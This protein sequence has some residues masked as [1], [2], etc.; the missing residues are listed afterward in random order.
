M[1][2]CYLHITACMGITRG[3][4]YYVY[5]GGGDGWF[6]NTLQARYTPHR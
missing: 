2:H 3:L 6:N 4:H 5:Y 1:F